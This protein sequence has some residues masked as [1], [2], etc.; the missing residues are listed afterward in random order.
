M[1]V[2]YSFEWDPAKAKANLKKHD[3]SFETAV[4]VFRDPLAVTVFDEEHTEDEDRWATMG[5]AEKMSS[6]W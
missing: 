6:W 5:L 3:V 4:T 2:Q 1:S